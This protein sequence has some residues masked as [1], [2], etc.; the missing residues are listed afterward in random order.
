MIALKKW[1]DARKGRQTLLAKE[2]RLNLTY[3]SQI[4]NSHRP[5]P[6]TAMAQIEQLT[7]GAVTRKDMRPTDWHEIWPELRDKP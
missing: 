1:C 3:V 7:N 6:I 2:L 4:V 5:V